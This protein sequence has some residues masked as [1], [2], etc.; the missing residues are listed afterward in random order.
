MSIIYIRYNNNIYM[1][2][3]IYNYSYS[4]NR[5]NMYIIFMNEY[6]IHSYIYIMNEYI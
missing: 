6:I 5:I 3:I 4:Y 2:Y 1:K